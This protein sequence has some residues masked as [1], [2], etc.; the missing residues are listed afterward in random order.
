MDIPLVMATCQR[1]DN[2]ALVAKKYI[3][4]PGF[5]YLA[6]VMSGVWVDRKNPDPRSLRMIIQKINQGK[7]F[8]V[9]PEGT[10]SPT[11]ALLEAKQGAAYVAAK[12]GVPIIPAAVTG[13][14]T[15]MKSWLRLQRPQL[16]IHYG[17]PFT[18]PP[19][20]R[21][22]R[23]DALQKGTDEIMC[24]IAAMLPPSYWGFYA[25]HPRLKEL[26]GEEPR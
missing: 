17:E 1:I 13:P 10:R 5:K 15:A 4:V 20:E 9:A 12:T 25:D 14:E 6:K 21:K 19:L 2:T 23:D 7:M 3:S 11:K 22:T 26:L 24:R 18:L 8:C 16:T